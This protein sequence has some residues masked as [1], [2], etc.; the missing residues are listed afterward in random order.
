MNKTEFL[1][2]LEAALSDFKDEEKKEILYDYEEHFR[3]GEQNGKSEYE[4]IEELGDPNNIANQ[5]RTSSKQENNEVP[6]DKKEEDN[7]IIVPII[8]VCGLLLFNLIFILGPYL[9]I[10]GVIIGLLCAAIAIVISGIGI[11]IGTILAPL[12][13]VYINVPSGISGIGIIFLGIGITALGLLFLIGMWY[14]CKY[15]YRG[16]V[17]YI[18]W[19]L[20]IIKGR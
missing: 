13:P 14:V 7:P 20:K 18:N 17:K 1:H 16:T 5:Y 3:V 9:G 4:L 11:I 10:V 2:I 19:N 15:F 6:K 8:A 12:F